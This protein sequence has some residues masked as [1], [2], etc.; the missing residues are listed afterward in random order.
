MYASSNYLRLISEIKANN[1][2]LHSRLVG[3][4]DSFISFLPQGT[5][6]ILLWIMPSKDWSQRPHRYI[7]SLQVYEAVTKLNYR[8][9]TRM[10]YQFL[11]WRNFGKIQG[12]SNTK[13][14]MKQ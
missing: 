14:V 9:A 2:F 12:K 6:F 4:F 8:E 13:M 3:F 11:E 10:N 7:P 5:A 1:D